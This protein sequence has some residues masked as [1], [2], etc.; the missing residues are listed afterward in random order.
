MSRERKPGRAR[1]MRQMGIKQDHITDKNVLRMLMAIKT[2]PKSTPE[3]A[4]STS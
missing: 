1:H 4:D 3:S 2:A